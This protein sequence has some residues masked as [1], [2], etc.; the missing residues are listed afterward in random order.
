MSSSKA[1][2]LKLGGEV[3]C[4]VFNNQK[5]ILSMSSLS[6]TKQSIVVPSQIKVTLENS[7]L[8]F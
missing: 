1:L 6:I 2:D 7:N 8:N 4:Q 3:L 5:N